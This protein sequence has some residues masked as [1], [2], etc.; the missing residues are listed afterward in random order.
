MSINNQKVVDLCKKQKRLV[1]Y[2]D[3]QKQWISDGYAMYPLLGVPTLTEDVVRALYAL[4]DNVEV[5]VKD[6]PGQ[7]CYEDTIREERLT[8]YEKIQLRPLGAEV[9][10][11]RTQ[12]GVV[13]IKEKYLKPLEAGEGGDHQLYERTDSA[14]RTYIVAKAGVFVE[15]II[16]PV[17]NLLTAGWL[18]DLQELIGILQK[19]FEQEEE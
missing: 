9:S 19:T 15:A 14:G 1:L 6:A 2:G 13:F 18:N 11:L 8:Y 17:Q 3:G 10:T 5:E 4:P 12:R 7:Y 16:L